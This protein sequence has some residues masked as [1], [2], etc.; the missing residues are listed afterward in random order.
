MA[1]IEDRIQ[2]DLIKWSQQPGVRKAYPC[3][4]L[5]YHIPNER[6]CDPREGKR[7]KLM[8]VKRGVPDLCL[9]VPNKGYAGL[10]IE[11]KSDS[12]KLSDEQNW[13]LC[14]LT[15]RGY[16]AVVCY[17]FDSAVNTLLKYLEGGKSC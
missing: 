17:G 11:L 9:P 10:Y 7:L 12:G 2:M 15:N 16:K 5:L 3:L 1:R 4:K 8:G 6:I 14:E 13:W